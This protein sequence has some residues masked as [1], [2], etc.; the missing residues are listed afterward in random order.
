MS[1]RSSERLNE[2]STERAIKRPSE[3]AIEGPS[4]KTLQD[5]PKTLPRCS[6][7]PS[8]SKALQDDSVKPKETPCEL[9]KLGSFRISFR[10]S[11]KCFR[12]VLE[13]LQC[14]FD[15]ICLLS[16]STACLCYSVNSEKGTNP[17]Y[18]QAWIYGFV[19]LPI[20]SQNRPSFRGIF[21]LLAG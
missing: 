9:A 14:V 15:R 19:L 17:K 6:K 2:G 7:A 1:D 18:S 8:P 3:R 21:P 11:G 4:E 13:R 5:D 20:F 12:N 10:G 16:P